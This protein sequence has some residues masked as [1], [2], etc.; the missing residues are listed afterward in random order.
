MCG[1]H[2]WLSN[3][4][5]SIK[6]SL[7]LNN[8]IHRMWMRWTRVC[9]LYFFLF[10]WIMAIM[11]DGNVNIYLVWRTS[12]HAHQIHPNCTDV[13]GINE[14][15]DTEQT[16]FPNQNATHC[17]V[18]RKKQ[19]QKYNTKQQQQSS[20]LICVML[21]MASAARGISDLVFRMWIM[22]PKIQTQVPRIYV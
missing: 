21:K 18:H 13:S 20:P 14:Y 9:M 12:F 16:Y 7:C 5:H 19:K 8:H 15:I 4:N 6:L 10:G 2:C 1:C 11:Y 17:A 22:C 3:W